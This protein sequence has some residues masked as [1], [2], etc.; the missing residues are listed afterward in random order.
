MDTNAFRDM[1]LDEAHADA[2]QDEPVSADRLAAA[3]RYLLDADRDEA[4]TLTDP[5]GVQKKVAQALGDGNAEKTLPRK[6]LKWKQSK[7]WEENKHP[8]SHGKF[9]SKPGESGS[10]PKRVALARRSNTPGERRREELT[11][12][13]KQHVTRAVLATAHAA[14]EAGSAVRRAARRIARTLRAAAGKQTAPS[15]RRKIR[16]IARFAAAVEHV[17][18]TGFRASKGMAE[19]VTQEYGASPET[20]A[21]VGRVLAVVD[22]VAA[23]TVNMPATLAVAGNPWAA[24]ASSWI[25][26]ASLAYVA[27]ASLYVAGANASNPLATIR[28]A[29]RVIA[30]GMATAMHKSMELSADEVR[31]LVEFLAA[32]EQAG[33]ADWAMA[34][35]AAAIDAQRGEVDLA[36][37]VQTA[38]EALAQVAIPPLA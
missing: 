10:V 23:W 9:A 32:A 18:M 5:Q 29:R 36:A 7:G 26:V 30:A 25:P 34:L 3:L 13:A 17:V 38:G 33:Q 19:Q 1:V 2:K 27:G 31:A 16:K 21:R 6:Q 14:G 8:R 28:A 15:V 35:L 4:G 37:A 24:K 22:A 11:Q 20:A 12:A